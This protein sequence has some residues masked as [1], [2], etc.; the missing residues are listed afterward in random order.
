[1]PQTDLGPVNITY[2][3][4]AFFTVEF[5]DT[6]GNTT[7]PSGASISITYTNII[8][9][10]QTDLFALT[11]NNSFFNGTWSSTSAAPGLAPWTVTVTGFSTVAQIGIIRV[12][13]P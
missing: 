2:G 12:I 11:L 8:N 13:E 5:Y 6:N 1:M 4:S 9:V 7:V 10:E 3:N